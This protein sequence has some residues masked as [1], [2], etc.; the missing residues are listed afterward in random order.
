MKA[1][2]ARPVFTAVQAGRLTS[3]ILPAADPAAGLVMRW[4][5]G[6]ISQ[7]VAVPTA[8]GRQ[9]YPYCGRSALQHVNP[10]TVDVPEKAGANPAGDRRLNRTQRGGL[11]P[12]GKSTGPA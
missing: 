1:F 11:R 12:V 10:E 8:R 9:G 6:A 3:N 4:T 5:N 2:E 7:L